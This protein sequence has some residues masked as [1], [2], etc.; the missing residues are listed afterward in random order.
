MIGQIESQRQWG[1]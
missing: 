1:S